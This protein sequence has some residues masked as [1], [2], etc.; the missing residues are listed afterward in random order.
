MA[1]R[2]DDVCELVNCLVV[3]IWV[4]LHQ[5]EQSILDIST[6]GLGIKVAIYSSQTPLLSTMISMKMDFN[7]TPPG[8]HYEIKVFFH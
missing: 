8:F 7:S 2:F 6:K 3:M 5:R 4:N 1:E